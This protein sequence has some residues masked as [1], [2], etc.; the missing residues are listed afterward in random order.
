MYTVASTK[1]NTADKLV[2]G[3]IPV[4]TECSAVLQQDI[5]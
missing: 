2:L 3:G 5:I 1:G 4:H